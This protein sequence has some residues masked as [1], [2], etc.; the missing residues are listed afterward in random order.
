MPQVLEQLPIEDNEPVKFEKKQVRTRKPVKKQKR[1]SLRFKLLVSAI[2]IISASVA[3]GLYRFS[4]WND[5][6][7]LHFQ[8]PIQNFIRIEPRT[9]KAKP[10]IKEAQ[11]GEIITAPIYDYDKIVDAIYML[12]S[13]RGTAYDGCKEKGLVNGFGYAQ[14]N[15]TWQCF[16]SHQEVRSKVR[17]WFVNNLKSMKL[18]E[19]LCYYNIGVITSDCTYY[20]N[21]KKV[22]HD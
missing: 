2:V 19:S 4:V 3:Y 16:K 5:T 20:S 13:T 1:I 14:S 17:A 18:S 12:E 6:W 9:T 7:S 22:Y 15:H 10:L 8:S 11:A 21:F